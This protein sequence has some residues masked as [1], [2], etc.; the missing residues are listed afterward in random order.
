MYVVRWPI[1]YKGK[2]PTLEKTAFKVNYESGSEV[3]EVGEIDATDLY[4]VDVIDVVTVV[5]V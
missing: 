5:H 2:S 4:V 3:G 1:H